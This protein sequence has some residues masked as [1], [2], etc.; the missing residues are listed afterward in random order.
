MPGLIFC[1]RI[2]GVGQRECAAEIA[3]VSPVVIEDARIPPGQELVDHS[4][5]N[6]LELPEHI[7]DHRAVGAERAIG[8]ANRDPDALIAVLQEA[9]AKR[10]FAEWKPLLESIDIPWE[11]IASIEDVTNDPQV[12]AN[13][14]MQDLAVGDARVRI[15]AGPT[16]FDGEAICG[17]PACSPALGAHTEELLREVGY[18][19]AAIADLRARGVAL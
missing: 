15:V 9:F 14:M 17:T 6:Q 18:G 13:G 7:G 12:R 10:D 8:N 1:F 5:I 16:A 2:L 3:D 19:E 11:S 4:R